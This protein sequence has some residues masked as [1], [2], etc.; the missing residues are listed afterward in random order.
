MTM[1]YVQET[2]IHHEQK[3]KF[4]DTTPVSTSY[5]QDAALLGQ[6]HKKPP[7][8][9]SCNEVGHVQRYC[10]KKKGNMS[11]GAAIVEED[12]DDSTGEGAFIIPT[13]ASSAWLVDSGSF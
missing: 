2:L 13:S 8:C 4:K 7:V 11:H 10:P 3:V 1:D 5:S 6:R 12:L 9:W